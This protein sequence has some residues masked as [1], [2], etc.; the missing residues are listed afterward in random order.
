MKNKKILLFILT[1]QEAFSAIIPFF[2]FSSF[3]TLLYYVVKYFHIDFGYID[4]EH[5]IFI[6][7]NNK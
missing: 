4:K 1:L 6:Y 7:E 3:V 5:Y 2:L